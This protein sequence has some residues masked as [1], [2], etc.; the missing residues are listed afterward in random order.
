[1]SFCF[2]IE[3]ERFDKANT[4][5]YRNQLFVNRAMIS[6]TPILMIIMYGLSIWITWVSAGRIDAGGLQV[7]TMTAFIAYAM[8]IVFSFLMIGEQSNTDI[9]RYHFRKAER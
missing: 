1:M 9:T 4:D 7:G 5:L 3:E 2:T 8:E 6:I